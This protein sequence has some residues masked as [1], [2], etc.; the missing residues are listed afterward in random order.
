MDQVFQMKEQEYNEMLKEA[1]TAVEHYTDVVNKYQTQVDRYVETAEEMMNLQKSTKHELDVA[2]DEMNQQVEIFE[3][4]IE[5]WKEE[6]EAKAHRG[7]LHGIFEI[8]KAIV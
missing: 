6:Q 1:E 8:G 3:E 7:V 2:I 4:N 5:E